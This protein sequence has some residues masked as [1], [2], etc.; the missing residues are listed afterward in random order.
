MESYVVVGS[1]VKLKIVLL[2][3]DVDEDAYGFHRW[4][5]RSV[6]VNDVGASG[7]LLQL[8]MFL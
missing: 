2:Y 6:F 7:K 4:F 1:L 8:I 3:G 5:L